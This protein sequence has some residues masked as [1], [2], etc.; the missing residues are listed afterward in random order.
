MDY[1]H[2]IQ[3]VCMY[4][5]HILDW[6]ELLD[7]LLRPCRLFLQLNWDVQ[8]K[9]YLKFVFFY[10]SH[11]GKYHQQPNLQTS[12]NQRIYFIHT[13]HNQPWWYKADRLSKTIYYQ[14]S[15]MGHKKSFLHYEKSL[16]LT[17]ELYHRWNYHKFLPCAALSFKWNKQ[18]LVGRQW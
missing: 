5:I 8:C 1:I 18:L 15:D 6:S 3:Y 16:T 11:S 14:K 12:T 10:E 7:Q 13:K 2:R 9:F 4:V 17:H